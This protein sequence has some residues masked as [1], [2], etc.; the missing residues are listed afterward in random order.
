M[1]RRR[2]IKQIERELSAEECQ[3]RDLQRTVKEL[4]KE[5]TRLESRPQ[6]ST[7]KFKT[8]KGAI[9]MDITVHLSDKAQTATYTEFAGPSGTGA[10]VPPISTVAYS[11]DNTSAVTVDS[12]SGLLAYV[13]VG[14]ANISASDGG[15]LP[16]SGSVTV[17]ADVVPAQS[18][19]LT[20][21]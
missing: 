13:G 8:R 14:V 18:S 12:T 15:N 10:V 4:Q 16:A 7:L 1:T 19:T 21:A 17:L 3:I 20:F 11:S 5:I 2:V 6:S 9:S